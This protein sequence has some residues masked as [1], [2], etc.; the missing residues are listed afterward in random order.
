MT[1]KKNDV[2]KSS[3]SDPDAASEA[4][5]EI[6]DKENEQGYSG[7]AVD[8]T[9]NENYTLAGVV[10][11]KPTPETH[12]EQAAKVGST[13]FAGTQAAEKESK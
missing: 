4:V 1:D 7:V 5:Q 11:N 2:E 9:P 8:P 10:D 13:K 3:T 6:V 12:P